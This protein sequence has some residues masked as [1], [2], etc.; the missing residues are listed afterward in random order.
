[1][2]QK[3]PLYA[4]HLKA[5]AKLVDFAGWLMPVQFKGIIEEH[6]AVRQS[7]GI[8][9]IGHMGQIEVFDKA[10]LQRLTTNDLSQ[11]SEWEGQY[12]FMCN[13]NGAVEDDL[14]IYRLPEKFLVISNAVNSQKV[15][16][17]IK[18]Q[19]PKAKMLYDKS[20]AIAVQGPF[21]VEQ[22]GKIL[23]KDLKKLKHR[24][25]TPVKIFGA[26]DGLA[27]RSG[28]SGEDG[29]E[30]FFDKNAAKD[31]WGKLIMERFVPC[32]LGSRD[33]LRIE[34]A[35]PLYGHEIDGS[36]T[37]LD[38][39]FERFV[40]F[41]KGD[42]V[43]KDALLSQKKSGAAKKLIGFDLSGRAV[44]RQGHEI[45]DGKKKIGYVTS[46]TYSPTLKKP[47]GIAYLATDVHGKPAFPKILI[48]DSSFEI[49]FVDL[50]FYRRTKV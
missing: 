36:T 34:S 19:D 38:A 32:G 2:P 3:T 48:R 7:A 50:P 45:F 37:P 29:I 44:P 5:G 40:K 26:F 43:G 33:T 24:Q 13:D 47:V 22:L 27:S 21:A 17:I 8:F 25:I 49:S 1:M 11:L 15:F 9:D 12:S 10:A 23:N 41:E 35:L 6:N 4:D 42:F 39:G 16:A 46:G 31:L 14:I 30:L 20:T 28:Y 18:G